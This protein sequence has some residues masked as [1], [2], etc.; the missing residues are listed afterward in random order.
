MLNT[1]TLELTRTRAL[2]VEVEALRYELEQLRGKERPALKEI[3]GDA[4]IDQ[5]SELIEMEKVR[6]EFAQM[7]LDGVLLELEEAKAKRT[8]HQKKMDHLESLAQELKSA[9]GSVG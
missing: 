8:E 7:Q 6:R 1:K 4:P 2:K 3:C 9:A 5:A